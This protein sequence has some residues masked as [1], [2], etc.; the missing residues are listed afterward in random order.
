[1]Q[2]ARHP[3]SDSVAAAQATLHIAPTSRMQADY[4]HTPC[5]CGPRRCATFQILDLH[6][7]SWTALA[8]NERAASTRA[9]SH[10]SSVAMGSVSTH[11]QTTRLTTVQRMALERFTAPTPMMPAETQCMVETG[12]PN[13]ETTMITSP[14]PVP[15][16]NPLIGCRRTFLCPSV[17]MMCQPHAGRSLGHKQC[18]PHH[19][20]GLQVDVGITRMGNAKKGEP[21]VQ[22]VDRAARGS[23]HRRQR[24]DALARRL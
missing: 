1:M 20:P 5:R 16:T 22:H 21:L 9:T 12:I 19:R 3:Q 8:Q 13:I 24:Q 14:E 6:S 17:L 15:A 23:P 4:P 2:D 10:P 7:G 11:A 18:A